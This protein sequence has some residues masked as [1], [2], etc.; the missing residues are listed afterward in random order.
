MGAVVVA[1]TVR[2]RETGK[3]SKKYFRPGWTDNNIPLVGPKVRTLLF[4]PETAEQIRENL[5][6]RIVDNGG[7]L[8]TGRRWQTEIVRVDVEAV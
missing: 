1:I 6:R 8:L 3:L 7:C 5:T 4:N 2:S